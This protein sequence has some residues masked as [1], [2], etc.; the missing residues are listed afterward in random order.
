MTDQVCWKQEY[1]QSQQPMFIMSQLWIHV[2]EKS[3]HSFVVFLCIGAGSLDSSY[4]VIS[5]CPL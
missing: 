2:Y 5:D 1:S 3:L 4:E